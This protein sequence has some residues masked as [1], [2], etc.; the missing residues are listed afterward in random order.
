MF[1]KGSVH[2]KVAKIRNK[3]SDA[4]G[5]NTSKVEDIAS[6]QHTNYT[7]FYC[8]IWLEESEFVHM[9]KELCYQLANSNVK[10]LDFVVDNAPWNP[11][12]QLPYNNI[13]KAYYA[14]VKLFD[15]Y[16]KLLPSKKKDPPPQ[17]LHEDVASNEEDADDDIRRP[18]TTPD[19]RR[20]DL[21]DHPIEQCEAEK[22]A[23]LEKRR[24]NS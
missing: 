14:A 9:T 3:I 6:L 24:K 1:G 23:H 20:E 21:N 13:S 15:A 5:L 12:D 22:R 8:S 11:T 16:S 10:E 2:N 19:P 4:K 17:P 7:A 18:T